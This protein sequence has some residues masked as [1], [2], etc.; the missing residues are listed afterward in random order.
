M[1]YYYENS[2]GKEIGPIDEDI[3]IDRARKGEITATTPVRNAMVRGYKNA[4]KIPCLEE[5]IKEA[6]SSSE[7]KP[8]FKEIAKNLH[9]SQ[10]SIKA[11]P[12]N[13]RLL[14]FTLDLIIN[15][16][17][18]IGFYNLMKGIGTEQLDEERAMSLFL[19]SVL[20]IPLIY[21][22]F[23]LGLKAQTFGYWFFGIMVIKGKGEEVF[24][25]RAFFMSLLFIL[26]LP[27]E[28]LFI[29]IF[30]KGL[31]ESFTGTRVVNV[32]LG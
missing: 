3:L 24:V 31:H 10:S 27:I 15:C 18:I 30:S 25:G 14:A 19:A 6:S 12:L 11:P 8:T 28:P 1:Q 32:R 29:F 23:C 17:L 21:Y 26:T 16:I 9:R 2:Q 13:F 5:V 20:G 22:S 7:R 4:E